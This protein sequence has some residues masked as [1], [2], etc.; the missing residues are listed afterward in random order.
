[1]MAACGLWGVSAHDRYLCPDTL[2]ERQVVESGLVHTP[3]PLDTAHGLE[4]WL[5]KKPVKAQ[6]CLMGDEMRS[7]TLRLQYA[8]CTGKRAV[9]S[10]NDPDYATYG[11]A[12]TSLEVGGD[13]WE[14]YNQLFFRVRP[15]CDG[16]RVVNLNLVFENR[17]QESKAGYN[18]PS[19][20][21]L[22]NLVNHQWNTCVV[23]IDEYQRDEVER[24][25]FYTV[26]NGRDLTTGD[27][28]LYLIT[29][30]QLRQVEAPEKVSGW[31]P[32]EGRIVYATS[33]YDTHGT[34][35]ALVAPQSLPTPTASTFDLVDLATDS[36]VGQWPVDMVDTT[37]GRYGVMD[38]SSWTQPGHY[39]LR[40]GGM[41]TE[42]FMI[43]AQLW[44]NSQWRVLNFLLGQ[45]CGYP[46]PGVHSTCHYDL[47]STHAGKSISFSGGWH[48]A[49][50]LSQQTLQTADMA[51]S[52][53]QAYKAVK[54]K[55]PAL[56]AR[57][58]EEAEWGLEFVLRN[59]YGDG[60]HASS[61]GLLIWQD[62]VF[63]TLD[64]IKSV[65]VQN[66]AYDNFLY[67][68]YEAYAA[69]TLSNDPML[70]QYLRRV[71]EED[72]AF[73]E[74][75][76]MLD[77]PDIFTQPYEHTFYTSPCLYQA[78]ISWAASLLYRLTGDLRYAQRAAMAMEYVL[79][80]QEKGIDMQEP[81]LRGYFYRDNT[82]SSL[83]HAI[84]QS[85]EHLYIEALTE[86]CATQ[87]LHDAYPQWA[88]A[89][90]LYGS[91]LKAL[92]AFTYP[93]GML[94]SGVYKSWEPQ[95]TAAFYAIHLFP[96]DD[97]SERYHAQLSQGEMVAEGTYVKRFPVWF[98]IY[99]GN[100]AVHLTSGRCAA[101]CG[102]FLHDDSLMDIARQQLYWQTGLNPFGQSLIYGEGRLYPQMDNF[103]SG[104]LTGAMPVGI[105]TL[106]DS[107]EPY[108]PQTNNACYKEVWVT[109]ASKWLSL[110][111]SITDY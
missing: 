5:M 30:L 12:S 93:Y 55:N 96:P 22:I 106:G 54:D 62:G 87:P 99:N 35:R 32:Q 20:A 10:A 94:P 91:H 42:P 61:M 25:T 4:A 59:R 66:N 45:R 26:I 71:A 111:A 81:L 28:A 41:E 104:E 3:L 63:G 58:L 21:H 50:D 9:G 69:M 17:A 65:R 29:D 43:D 8:S 15:E 84:H 102:A 108:W 24:L 1:M 44:D 110:L 98:N 78:T 31:M 2:L 73:A 60:Y 77:G 76:Y 40:A 38:F 6:R 47:L 56:A 100:T 86:L 34:K 23:E 36:V 80:C 14:G 53:L 75:K 101:L 48:D 89:I 97:A 67:A 7:D 49:G 103:S 52:L 19:G 18:T 13:D 68:A 105:R 92:M 88:K 85:R 46:V 74:E 37:I 95:D 109:S 33:G 107:D 64:D 16:A 79:D 70:Q 39:Y 57:L 83:A 90:S 51:H 72:F 27:S 11:R 82:H